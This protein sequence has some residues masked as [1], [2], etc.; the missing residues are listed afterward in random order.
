MSSRGLRVVLILGVVSMFGDFVYEG[1]RSVLPDFM[2]QLGMSAF[3]IGTVLGLSELA[4]WVARPLGGFVADRTGRLTTIVWIGYAGL[5]VVPLMAFAGSWYVLALLVFAERVL[6]G[7]RAPGR[8]AM[9][10]RLRSGLGLGMAFG[11]HELLDQLGATLGPLLAIIITALTQETR[12]VFLTLLI[13]YALLL[14]TLTKLPRYSE[15]PQTTP[16]A[17]PPRKAALFSAAVGLNAAGLLPISIILYLVSQDA[18]AGSWLVPAAYTTAMVV[19]AA[20]AVLLGRAFDRAGPV[21]LAVTM[22]LAVAPCL[23]VGL[24]VESLFLAAALVGV[25]ISAQESVFR[26]MVAQLAADGG[27]GGSYAA[28]G[29]ALGVG[30]AAAGLVYGLMV[31]LG[32]GALHLLAY[33][34]AMQAA[35]VAT[36]LKAIEK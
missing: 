10:A 18:G 34:A 19:D 7:L 26:A 24:G 15:S 2:R 27:L 16:R 31:D 14:A 32:L 28:Y 4:G 12:H 35:A 6:R 5:I 8:D 30:S 36:L 3:L 29:L 17:R 20:A 33:S 25:V 9:L 23:L 13:P 22:I 1:G 11:I 21:V